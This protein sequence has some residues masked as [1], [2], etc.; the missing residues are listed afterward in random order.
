MKQLAYF[1]TSSHSWPYQQNMSQR[2]IKYKKKKLISKISF[3]VWTLAFF[4]LP[5]MNQTVI[6]TIIEQ[7]IFLTR[8]KANMTEN[9]FKSD[10]ISTVN[11]LINLSLKATRKVGR[12]PKRMGVLK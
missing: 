9:F 7:I 2:L 6:F 4:T 11:K 10:Q 8:S 3:Y 1:T 12:L 5:P